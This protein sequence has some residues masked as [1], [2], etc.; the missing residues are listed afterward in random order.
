MIEILKYDIER[1]RFREWAQSVLDFGDLENLHEHECGGVR[2]PGHRAHLF[3]QTMKSAFAD[4]IRVRFGDFVNEYVT[5]RVP[6]IPWLEIY[7]NFRIHEKGQA[8]TSPMHRDREYLTER[9]SLKIWLPFT[10]VSGGSALWCESEEGK[11]DLKAYD[12]NYGEA[13]FFDSLNLLHGC[14]FNDSANTRLSMD[15]IVRPD[16]KLHLRRHAKPLSTDV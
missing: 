14:H 5:S 2:R 3:I 8:T 4:D 12:M 1:Y 10:L 9:G 13:L 16:P 11:N 15:F 6:F 7:P